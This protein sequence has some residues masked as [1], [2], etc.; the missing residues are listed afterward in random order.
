MYAD[1]TDVKTPL[2]SVVVDGRQ[3]QLVPQVGQRAADD[4]GVVAE[5]EAADAG[6]QRQHPHGARLVGEPAVKSEV[7]GIGSASGAS[8]IDNVPHTA[9]LLCCD[10]Q[11][12]GNRRMCMADAAAKS[13]PCVPEMPRISCA[14]WHSGLQLPAQVKQGC[15]DAPAG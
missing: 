12:A 14:V 7:S 11:L 10:D 1:P 5:Q 15:N 8:C 2:R 13:P 4:A 6:K 3:Q 9:G